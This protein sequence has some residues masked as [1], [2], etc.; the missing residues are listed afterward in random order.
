[1]IFD[2]LENAA[3]Y[4]PLSKKIKE[5]FLFIKSTNWR[6]LKPGRYEYN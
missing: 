3:L 1:M 6:N 4:Y 5:A 2:M